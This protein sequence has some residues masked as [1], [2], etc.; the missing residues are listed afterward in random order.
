[1]LG[2]VPASLEA[3][4]KTEILGREVIDRC[5]RLGLLRARGLSFKLSMKSC[6]KREVCSRSEV[7]RTPF[8]RR[9][10]RAPSFRRCNSYESPRT[11]ILGFFKQNLTETHA[12]R[13]NRT[14]SS[15]H[16]KH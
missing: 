9:G 6:W 7:R 4:K 1:M 8:R 16:P 13:I 12:L 2:I 11:L 14:G 10:V 3:G 5:P 15:R